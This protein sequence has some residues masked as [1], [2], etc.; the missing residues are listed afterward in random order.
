MYKKDENS[1]SCRIFWCKE[2]IADNKMELNYEFLGIALFYN[3]QIDILA[4]H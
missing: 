1:H 2:I 3:E 4:E